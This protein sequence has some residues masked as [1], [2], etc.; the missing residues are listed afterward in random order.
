MSE[1]APGDEQSDQSPSAANGPGPD[2]GEAALEPDDGAEGVQL[3]MSE[4]P[5]S[6]EPEEDPDASAP[7]L[8]SSGD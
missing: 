1:H 7:D 6:F 4:E 8:V 2:P 5:N 3:T